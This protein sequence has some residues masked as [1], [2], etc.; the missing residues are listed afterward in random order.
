MNN[1]ELKEKILQEL[2]RQKKSESENLSILDK[3]RTSKLKR[4][5]DQRR[6]LMNFSLEQIES[7]Y[8]TQKDHLDK[9]DKL[10]KLVEYKSN[11]PE[12]FQ[13]KDGKEM[14]I[15]QSGYAYKKGIGIYNL[16]RKTSLLNKI[17]KIRENVL[18]QNKKNKTQTQSNGN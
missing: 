8:Q 17:L 11:N 14:N 10:D 18:I 15:N 12:A 16:E 5:D 7:N 13:K 9:F 2:S 1:Q 4:L 3:T 6:L